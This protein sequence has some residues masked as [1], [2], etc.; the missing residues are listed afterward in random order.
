MAYYLMLAAWHRVA[1]SRKRKHVM[2]E[3]NVGGR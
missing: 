3:N 1:A 2:F